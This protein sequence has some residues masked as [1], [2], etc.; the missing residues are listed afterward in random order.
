M[1]ALQ[2]AIASGISLVVF[3]FTTIILQYRNLRSFEKDPFK[4]SVFKGMLPIMIC[5]AMSSLSG[6]ALLVSLLFHFF[7]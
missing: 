7:N 5:G 2:F 6:L 3:V 1:T 4:S